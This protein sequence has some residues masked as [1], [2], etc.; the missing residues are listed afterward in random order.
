VLV[1]VGGLPATGKTTVS[2]ALAR[3]VDGIHL[4]ID[5]IE[6]AVVRW[7]AGTRPPGPVGYGIGYALADDFVRQGR[8]VVADSVNPLTVTRDAWRAVAVRAGVGYLE[9]EVVCSDEVEH[10]RRAEGRTADIPDLRLPG[11]R[12]IV[13]RPYEG[14][15]R[16]HLVLETAGR[17]VADCVLEVLDQLRCRL[18]R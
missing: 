15:N 18:P 7:G 10:R 16:P 13:N 9:V 1:I 11:W 5:T 2:R 14:W 3:A 12:D 4:R 8:T 17:E 6:Q